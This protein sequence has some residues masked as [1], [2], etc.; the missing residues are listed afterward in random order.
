MFENSLT[1]RLFRKDSLTLPSL[2]WGFPHA[3]LSSDSLT[4]P[5]S[6]EDSLTDLVS[7]GEIFFF[8]MLHHKIFH[9]LTHCA[10]RN[11]YVY[12]PRIFLSLISCLIYPRWSALTV[13]LNATI[14]PTAISRSATM[15]H[16]FQYV[17]GPCYKT[18]ELSR[19]RSSLK[20]P[21]NSID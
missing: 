20:L 18:W 5:S 6:C 8:R 13:L 4:V 7:S 17:T 9:V 3:S 10:K 11:L 15:L 12:S 1:V 14:M 19:Q 21:W 16:Y 2:P